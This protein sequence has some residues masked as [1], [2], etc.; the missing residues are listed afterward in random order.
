M[1]LLRL[2]RLVPP[3]KPAYPLIKYDGVPWKFPPCSRIIAIGD[4]H[5]DLA[6]AAALLLEAD[7]INDE[8]AWI[9]QATKLV[10]LGDLIGGHPDS[11]LLMDFVMRLEN[12]ARRAGGDVI[13]LLGNHDL[14]PVQGNLSKFSGKEKRLFS[15][16]PVAGGETFKAK[17]CFQGNSPY[18]KWIRQR[19]ALVQIGDILFVHAG[20]DRWALDCDIGQ[21]NATIRAWIRFWQGIDSRPPKETRWTVGKRKMKRASRWEVGP[22]WNRTFRVK[23]RKNGEY[24]H[25]SDDGISQDELAKAL[26]F[27]GA[28]RLI[29]GHSPI[30]GGEPLLEH[31]YYGETVIMADT[32]ISDSDD[33]VS[34]LEWTDGPRVIVARKR[35]P[36]AAVREREF[37]RLNSSR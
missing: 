35:K 19:N 37:E 30:D 20:L 6:A 18:A 23:L 21:T 36:G 27:T 17:Q 13:A 14:L 4:L 11:R 22:L 16:Y 5:G 15:D 12:E 1:W 3:L 34:A 33:E 26:L 31:P 10:L 7:L 29:V 9:G 25:Q 24:R 8:G 28:K 32:R 2:L